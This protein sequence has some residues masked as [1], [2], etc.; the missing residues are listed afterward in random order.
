MGE[1]WCR[2]MGHDDTPLRQA[3][4][5]GGRIE[6]HGKFY[7]GHANVHILIDPDRVEYEDAVSI[8]NHRAVKMAP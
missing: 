3:G 4:Y 8:R 2:E 7:P 5:T 6:C 1:N